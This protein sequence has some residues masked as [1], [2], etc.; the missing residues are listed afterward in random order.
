MSLKLKF[1][2]V[3]I[4]AFV[5]GLAL[6]AVFVNALSERIARRAVFSEAA[7]IMAELEATIEYSDTDVSPLL[8][9]SMKVQFLPQSIPFFAAQRT[10][11]LL[12]REQP[13]YSLRQ[14]ADNPTRPSDRPAPW[15]AEIIGRFRTDPKLASLTTERH[16]DAGEIMSFSRPVRL[17]DPACLACHST[18][19]AAPSSMIDVYGSKNGFG[20]ALG[21]V[22]GAQIVSVPERVALAR[23]RTSLYLI[24]GG[25]AVVFAVMLLVL[26]LLL[27]AMIVAPIRSIS[28]TADDVSLGNLETPEFDTHANDEI[29]SLAVSFNRMRR[30]LV[31]AFQMLEE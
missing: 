16:T 1:N 14:P 11:D 24:M 9:H 22:V 15:E 2:L 4:T 17:K 19:E 18:P 10:F 28:R 25:L 27:Q 3:M 12:A 7:T 8:T 26:N 6:A 31:A 5:A 30:S 13:D 23:G 29:G 21:S 20:W